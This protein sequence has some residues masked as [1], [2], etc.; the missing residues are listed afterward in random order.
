MHAGVYLFLK[1]TVYGNNSIV[2]IAEIGET[3]T[4]VGATQNNGLQCIT[5]KMP[6]CR[7]RLRVGEWVF[8]N[9]SEVP[10]QGT[11]YRNRGRDDGTVNLNFLSTDIMFP[12]QTGLFC[13]VVPDA[14]D[15][16]QTVC[17]NIS[18]LKMNSCFNPI[19]LPQF[20]A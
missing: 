6:C 13:C 2:P 3:N 9:G 16:M 17:S 14:N 15:I 19:W 7:F 1:G 11:F 5:D 4:S 10:M 20:H 18:E 12:L 8:P